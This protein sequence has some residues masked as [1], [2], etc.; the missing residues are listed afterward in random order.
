MTETTST[1]FLE[2][3][4]RDVH[5]MMAEGLY[6]AA[7]PVWY[8]TPLMAAMRQR[9]DSKDAGLVERLTRYSFIVPIQTE[10]ETIYSVRPDER[11]I[12]QRSW[13]TQ[14]PQAY[15][16]AHQHALAY[17]EA[18]PD[19]NPFAQTQ[20]RLYHM[21]FVN[22]AAAA[23]FLVERFRVYHNDRQLGAIERL[24][25]TVNEA[26][27]Y[28]ELLNDQTIEP[29]DD[30]LLHLQA[31]LAQLRGQWGESLKLLNTLQSKTTLSSRLQPYVPRAVGFALAQTGQYVEAM[32]QYR[33]AIGRFDEQIATAADP[34]ALQ[35]EKAN[36]IIALG[37]AYADLAVTARGY[38]EKTQTS[39]HGWN[40][41]RDLFYFFL[42]LPIM[43]YLGFHLG[44]RVLHP[45]FWPVLRYLD[46]MV[47]RLFALAAQQYH[48]ADDILEKYGNP[49]EGVTA[50][51][52]LANL[53]LALGD[54][55]Q[56]Q[57]IFQRLLDQ[58]GAPLGE[59]RRTA[60]SIGLAQTDLRLNQPQAAQQKL[61]AALPTLTLYE[62]N[63]L[64]ADTHAYLG[65]TLVA[66]GQT[67]QAIP[68]YHKSLHLYQPLQDM[69]S[70]TEVSERLA[71]LGQQTEL[72]L[73]QYPVRYRHIATRTFQRAALA[74]LALLA[75]LI[76][77]TVIRFDTS[78]N[79]AP[80]ITF[81]AT[82]LLQADR[83]DF[84]PDLSQGVL[85]SNLVP[86]PNPDVAAWLGLVMLAVYLVL[87]TAVGVGAIARTSLQTIQT[88]TQAQ[89]IQLTP[90]S[91]RSGEIEIPLAEVTHLIRADVQVMNLTSLDN[92][93][94]ALVAPGKRLVI[95]GNTAEYP[96]LQR[97]LENHLQAV[98]QRQ[99][100]SYS[101]VRSRSGGLFAFTLGMLISI[102]TLGVASPETLI[103]D[104]PGTPY[105]VADLYPYLYLGL[106]IPGMWWFI[107]RPL[108]M[109]HYLRPTDPWPWWVGGL[110]LLILLLRFFTRF[111]AWLTVPDIYPTLASSMMVG[112]LLWHVW[113]GWFDRRPEEDMTRPSRPVYPAWVVGITAVLSL[114]AIFICASHLW[115]EVRAYHYLVLGN[116]YRDRA[117]QQADT[118]EKENLIQQAADA[119]TR[120]LQIADEKVAGFNSRAS[121][122]TPVGIPSLEQSIWF[123]AL[124]SRAAMR[125]QLGQYQAAIDDYTTLLA[126]SDAPDR[127]YASRA[128]AYLGIGTVS[129]GQ[130]MITAD[131][132]EYNT[133]LADFDQAIALSPTNGEYYL[134]RAVAN[135]ALN[136]PAEALG[137]YQ[138]SLTILGNLALNDVQRSQAFTGQGWIY[139]ALNN[140][141]KAQ[142]LFQQA[143]TADSTSSDARIGVGYAYY[144]LGQFDQ[145]ITVWEEA[146][147]LTPNNPA[148]PIL[149]GTVYWRKGSVGDNPGGEAL[150]RCTEG[151][152]ETERLTA[153]SWYLQAAEQF[154]RAVTLPGQDPLDV[155]F[156]YRTLAQVQFLLRNCP[157]QDKVAVLQATIDSY[158]RAIEL[159]PTNAVYYH[160]RGRLAYALWQSLPAGT[161]PSARE[162]LFQAITDQEQALTLEPGNQE[163]ADWLKVTYETA[164]FGTMSRGDDAFQSGDYARALAYYELVTQNQPEV[165]EALF[166]AGLAALATR[167]GG[168]AE[169]YYQQAIS[170]AQAIGANALLQ[171]AWTALTT[172]VRSH[173]GVEWS[174]IN[175]FFRGSNL[176]LNQPLDATTAFALALAALSEADWAKSAEF[177]NRGIELASANED[178]KAVNTAAYALRDYLLAHPEIDETRVYWPLWEDG[179]GR[180]T[181]VSQLSRPDLFWRYRAEFGFRL[182]PD[183]FLQRPGH[184]AAY[185]T[186]FASVTSDM[187]RAYTLNPEAFQRWRDFFV[188]SNMGWFYLRR[189][190]SWY[191]AGEYLLALADY[192]IA[193]QRI[194]PLSEAAI[195]D[196][197][198]A[199]YKAGLAALAMGDVAQATDWYNIGAT[200]SETYGADETILGNAITQ[201]TEL[202]GQQPAVSEAAGTILQ[203]LDTTR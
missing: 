92:S 32:A 113:R 62:D 149:L 69:V 140:Y 202:V 195:N 106:F 193:T 9:D 7:V 160:F 189:G 116:S 164:V 68:H 138:I 161:G 141:E 191:N 43:V 121:T 66:Q 120:S 93:S 67:A 13:I 75:F 174:N 87:S 176:E 154:S 203:E 34:A 20:N 107:I 185:E 85:A 25:E 12:L 50:D 21:L 175:D 157:N 167:D 117:V 55:Q 179:A 170:Q 23:D 168:K 177:Y 153:E 128:I 198:D 111:Y 74:L 73:R 64:L 82:P 99:D 8:N 114:V 194:Q 33:L 97:R 110:G 2:Q 52:K 142:E 123:S 196:L 78:S 100:F 172:F 197:T 54:A 186:I 41:L 190:D 125:S 58:S 146:N 98:T 36:T 166:K 162:G 5:P 105:S 42:S 188:H 38:Q 27:F 184:E 112:G 187:E 89:A 151:R 155:A 83:P 137:D 119:Y 147:T 101:L 84:R 81:N 95:D 88:T 143:I 40:L 156:T 145:A 65:E 192:T 45:S 169:T 47:A 37:D 22:P 86:P 31:R 10:G 159:D 127:V 102:A 181:A 26:R 53:Y 49:A 136:H 11:M 3:I 29:L 163:Y 79:V 15:R 115:R 48:R 76:P 6:L 135:H 199:T 96:A 131:Q 57:T 77:I 150:D 16:A 124:N 171:Q 182:L 130:G 103:M 19:P 59:Y 200:L 44:P 180:E 63:A 91:I 35:A 158:S 104:F 46:W 139:Y 118:S 133:A 51:E 28:L 4:L 122:Q 61:E 183:L 148:V 90:Q 94:L 14:N 71:E 108:Q 30:L 134:W 18:N 17:W 24:L 201:L 70:V 72:P 144:S 80:V 60:V 129:V 173:Q 39:G 132:N 165:L 1:L 56:A 152:S 178:S 109:R 126:F